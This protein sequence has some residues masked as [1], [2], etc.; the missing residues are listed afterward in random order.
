MER[1]KI[2]SGA[3]PIGGISPAGAHSHRVCAPTIPRLLSSTRDLR[4]RARRERSFYCRTQARAHAHARR[5]TRRRAAVNRGT[6][7]EAPSKPSSTFRP[8]VHGNVR[9]QDA[10]RVILVLTTR[11]SLFLPPPVTPSPKSTDATHWIA[12]RM[13]ACGTKSEGPEEHE[14]RHSP[15]TNYHLIDRDRRGRSCH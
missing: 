5:R 4:S 3:I 7:N 6:D 2:P 9:N 13:R 12:T 8:R 15:R 10:T 14:R 11:E 1:S